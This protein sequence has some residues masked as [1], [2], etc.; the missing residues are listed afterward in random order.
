MSNLRQL[1]QNLKVRRL[2]EAEKNVIRGRLLEL[3]KLRPV[4]KPKFLF[5]A[6]SWRLVAP[7]LVAVLVLALGGGTAF[8]A[9]GSL[10]G[11]SLYPVKVNFNEPIRTA[12]AF[13]ATAQAGVH[14]ELAQERLKEAEELASQNRLD[15]VVEAA[16]VIRVERHLARAKQ[17][18]SELEGEGKVE[19]AAALNSNLEATLQAHEDIIVKIED[20]HQ[21]QNDGGGDTQPRR[22]RLKEVLNAVQPN[23]RSTA[24]A[25][26][27]SEAKVSSGEQARVKSAAEN[28]RDSAKNTI[29][30]VQNYLN[31]RRVR[32][33][34]SEESKAK[35]EERL[36][37]AERLFAQ[38]EEKFAAGANGEAFVLFQTSA[39]VAQHARVLIDA[40]LRYGLDIQTNLRTQRVEWEREVQNQNDGE[41][42]SSNQSGQDRDSDSDG[43]EESHDSGGDGGGDDGATLDINLKIR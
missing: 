4:E 35:A 5:F 32:N 25:R 22:W 26:T 36:V 12:L 1:F 21:G 11:D 9:Q 14:S 28:K 20:E 17:H 10:P 34:L 6:F 38:G 13:S 18:I 23:V 15:D 3:M 41:D 2:S 40:G 37:E 27:Q 29:E 31:S 7:A 39:R 8:A 19:E 16:V 24:E 33:N 43:S 30:S 42:N